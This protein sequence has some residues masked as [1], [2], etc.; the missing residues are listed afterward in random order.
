MT[1]SQMLGVSIFALMAAPALAA[2]EGGDFQSETTV[3]ESPVV[4]AGVFKAKKEI[5]FVPDSILRNDEEFQ[6]LGDTYTLSKDEAVAI[7]LNQDGKILLTYLPDDSEQDAPNELFISSEVFAKMDLQFDQ[8]GGLEKLAEYSRYDLQEYAS[9]HSRYHYRHRHHRR[10]SG[11]LHW[12]TFGGCVAYVAR[13]EGFHGHAGNGV[14]MTRALFRTG[15]YRHVSCRDHHFGD[16]ISYSGNGAG[17]TGRWEGGCW[18]YDS[19][20]LPDRISGYREI[21]CV[22]RADRF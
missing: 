16:V 8:A 4:R 3:K 17:H 11:R 2:V 12:G 5:D 10:H 18:R 15:R 22:R 1:A 9:R 20:C 19:S 13:A 7:E 21:G 6:N 14:G